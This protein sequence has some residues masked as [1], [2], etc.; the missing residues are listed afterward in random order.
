MLAL[1]PSTAP[2]PNL[3]LFFFLWAIS[4]TIL[5]RVKKKPVCVS[6]GGGK[7]L[8]TE[9]ISMRME[10]SGWER[11]WLLTGLPTKKKKNDR[12]KSS[13]SERELQML[14][15]HSNEAHAASCNGSHQK[16]QFS[17]WTGAGADFCMSTHLLLSSGRAQEQWHLNSKAHVHRAPEQEHS[18]SQKWL[19]SR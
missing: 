11:D 8:Q 13:L 17:I 9:G 1:T 5:Y 15:R 7:A 6:T 10:G 3:G 18:P 14:T 2:C 4:W 19:V 12:S 16:I